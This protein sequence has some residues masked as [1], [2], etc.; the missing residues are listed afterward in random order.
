MPARPPVD[1]APP[2]ADG[3]SKS[4][5]ESRLS[6]REIRLRKVSRAL[7]IDFGDGASFRL[8]FEFLR[9]FSPSAEV[10]GHGPMRPDGLPQTLVAGKE[11]ISVAAVEPVGNYAVKIAFSD[12][13]DSGLFSWRLLRELGESRD[14]LWRAHRRRIEAESGRPAI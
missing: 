7:E 13:H 9:V 10:R 8:P 12:G 6:P 14:A 11:D 2:A 3:D 1:A 4:D 5:S